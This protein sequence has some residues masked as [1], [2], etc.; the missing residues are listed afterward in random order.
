MVEIN[1]F[2]RFLKINFLFSFVVLVGACNP[3]SIRGSKKPHSI[4]MVAYFS[5]T[6]KVEDADSALLLKFKTLFDSLNYTMSKVI[7][8][9]QADLIKG[10]SSHRLDSFFVQQLLC[11]AKQQFKNQNFMPTILLFNTGGLRQSLLKGDVTKGHIYELMPF[12][13]QLVLGRISGEYLFSLHQRMKEREGDPYWIL[14]SFCHNQS[15]SNSFDVNQID[16]LQNYYL[17]TTDFLLAGGD[18][19]LDK[20]MVEIVNIDSNFLIRDVLFQQL[21]SN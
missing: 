7:F 2:I 8:Y 15:L 3:F 14:G 20:H 13:N 9:N 4:Q 16:S 11:F 1:S 10:D 17:L 6:P 19:I 18:R 12:D 21:L 5:H